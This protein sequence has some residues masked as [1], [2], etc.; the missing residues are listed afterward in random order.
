MDL[1][2]LMRIK[3]TGAGNPPSVVNLLD[4]T[5]TQ[6]RSGINAESLSNGVID[7]S[8]IGS[9]NSDYL[10]WKQEFE[11]G[12]YT[13]SCK[14]EGAGLAGTRFLCT[15]EFAGGTYISAYT[16]YY[17]DMA[18][19]TITIEMSEAFSIGI[20]LR[21]QSGHAGEPGKVYD[22]MFETGDTPSPYVPYKG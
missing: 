3:A 7:D 6:K 18:E 9:G 17:A 19:D 2:M 12:T 14:H 5:S 13:F 16:A 11:A 20:C 15:K 8:S 21:T 22:I 1:K 4:V 10:L